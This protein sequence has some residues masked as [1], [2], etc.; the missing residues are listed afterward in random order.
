MM[1]YFICEKLEFLITHGI[2]YRTKQKAEYLT[3][4]FPMM[5]TN[6]YLLIMNKCHKFI[7]YNNEISCELS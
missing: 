5:K 4:Y 6:K 2:S 7:A 3:I 1:I